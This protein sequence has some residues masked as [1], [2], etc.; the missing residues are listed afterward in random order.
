MTSSST[1]L[2]PWMPPE[3]RDRQAQASTT[4]GS[5]QKSC[6]TPARWSARK[7]WLIAASVV[8]AVGAAILGSVWLGLAAVLPLLYLLPCLAMVAM[9]MKGGKGSS[10]EHSGDT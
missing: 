5:A 6:A 10:A 2:V 3:G 8:L 4:E 1:A 9:C 7:K